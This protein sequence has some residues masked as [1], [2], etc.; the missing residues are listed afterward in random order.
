MSPQ[1]L[2]QNLNYKFKDRDLLLEALTHKS[3]CINERKKLSHNERLEYL[4]DS[5]I[6]FV[7]AEHL[8]QLFPQD[9]E[10][11]LSKKRASLVNQ[12]VLAQKALNLKLDTLLILGPG[13]KE[14]E[15][16][17]KPRILCSAFEAILGAI[18]LDSD[19]ANIKAWIQ[20]EFN[21][22]IAKI[23]PDLEFERDYKTRLQELTQKLKLGMPDYQLIETS[24]PSHNPEFLVGVYLTENGQPVEKFRAAGKSKKA[25]EQ[26][27]AQLL[28]NLLET[29]YKRKM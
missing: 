20:Q 25:A 7:L 23:K 29:D 12:D 16:H 13:E 18:Y 14:Q 19:F 8:M 24:G 11:L 2:E 1:S 27:A 10:G 5:I 26:S 4:G 17:L 9:N 28:M 15:S 22:D 3:Y 6:G 21:A